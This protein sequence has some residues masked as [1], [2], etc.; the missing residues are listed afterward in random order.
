MCKRQR[1]KEELKSSQSKELGS[2]RKP[3]ECGIKR[4][5]GRQLGVK[6][7]FSTP[8]GGEVAFSFSSGGAAGELIF[9]SEGEVEAVY[10]PSVSLSIIYHLS[11]CLSIYLPVCLSIYT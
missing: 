4:V 11:V 8:K 6:E 7:G 9:F 5:K 3:G 2:R 10:L 1:E